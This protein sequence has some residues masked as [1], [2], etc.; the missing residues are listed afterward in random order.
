M[1]CSY[2]ETPSYGDSSAVE[3]QVVEMKVQLRAKKL[4]LA[5][6]RGKVREGK[7]GWGEGRRGMIGRR[8]RG[9]EE[10]IVVCEDDVSLTVVEV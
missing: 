10:E 1:P 5:A 8:G 9:N 7:R 6:I 2:A 4:D 3:G